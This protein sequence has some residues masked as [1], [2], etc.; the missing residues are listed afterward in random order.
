MPTIQAVD[1]RKEG[2]PPERG[3]WLSPVLTE[4]MRETLARGQQT[5]LFLNRRGYAPLTLCRSCG[6]RFDCPQCAAW[7]VEHRFRDRLACHHCGFSAPLPKTCPKCADTDSLIPCGPGVER[8]A[9][10]VAENLPDANLALLSSDLIT[11]LHDL[12][13]VLKRIESGEAQIIIGTQIVAKGHNFPNLALVGVVDGDLGL[14]QADPRAAERTFQLLHQ[15][16]GRAGRAWTEGRGLIQTH[17]PG[18]PVM[19]SIINGDREDFL[20]TEINARAK[21]EMPPYG[22]L[23]AIVISSRSRD[24]AAEFARTVSLRAPRSDKV[25]VLG[26]SEAPI[27]IIRSRYRYRILVKA[28]REIDLSGYMRAWRRDLPKPGGDLR[29][30]IDIDP[31]SFL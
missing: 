6:H 24:V 16:T 14:G 28:S 5:L 29:M 15:V 18:H 31:Y 20:E 2:D 27:S 3:K 13:A 4:A 9:E 22:R 26:P 7:L 10:E 30:A 21:A 19:K 25:L 17:M 8:I 23:A 1:L 12:R 11:D